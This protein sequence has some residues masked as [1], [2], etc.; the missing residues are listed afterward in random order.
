[1]W[2]YPYI[3][4]YICTSAYAVFEWIIIQTALT[5]STSKIIITTQPLCF[6]FPSEVKREPIGTLLSTSD[7]FPILHFNSVFYMIENN[8]LMILY[9]TIELYLL[10]K[11]NMSTVVFHFLLIFHAS[12]S[13]E[14]GSDGCVEFWPYGWNGRSSGQNSRGISGNRVMNG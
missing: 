3:W 1:M 10:N 9:D 7:L 2:L 11:C 8:S 6:S 13:R 12:L 4:L 5:I 14:D